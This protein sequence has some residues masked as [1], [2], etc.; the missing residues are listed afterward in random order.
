[1]RLL[2]NENMP[3][4]VVSE[5]RERGHDVLAVKESMRGAEDSVILARSQSECRLVITQDK[6]FGELAFRCGLPAQSGVILFRLS[7]ESAEADN[8]RI[9]DVID[10][11][12]DWAGHFAVAT[13]DRVRMRPL[14]P[15]KP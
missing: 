3:G 13:D 5:L 11:R 4:T 2:L 6:D 8:Q 7:G 1:M 15:A 9:L 10:S 12:S 14:P